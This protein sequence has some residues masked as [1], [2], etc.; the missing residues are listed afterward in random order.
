MIKNKQLIARILLILGGAIF[1]IAEF[2]TAAAW[3]HPAYSYT[4]NFISD[5]GVRGPSTLFGQYMISPLSWVMNTGFIVF[6]IVLFGGI[7]ILPL[8]SGYRRW[9]VIILG[10]LLA[11]GGVLV[12]VFHGSGEALVDGT[13]AY[14]SMGAFIAF[15]SGNVLFW[16]LSS[17]KVGLDI[18]DK[19]RSIL[20]YLSITGLVCTVLYVTTLVLSTDAHPIIIIGLIERGAVYPMLFNAIYLGMSQTK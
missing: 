10:L 2:I 12:G 3:S 11:I 18:S 7:L 9:I 16:V 15:I 1:F 17:K 8:N 19:S 13:G 20:K 14:H 5:L 6:G 4:Y